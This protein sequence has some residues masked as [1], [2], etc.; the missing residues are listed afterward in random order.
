MFTG[1]I[2]EIGEVKYINNNNFGTELEISCKKVLEKAMVGDSI[3]T[4]GVCLTI[5]KLFERSFLAELMFETTR[6]SNLSILKKGDKVNLEK[7]VRL[8]SFMGGHLVTGDVDCVGEII[9]KQNDGFSIVYTIKIPEDYMKFIV[10][11]GRV[12]IDGASLTISKDNEKNFQISLIP[13]S[14][15]NITLSEKKIGDKV[16]IETDIIGKYV[17][18]MVRYSEKKEKGKNCIVDEKFLAENGFF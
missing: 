9:D 10:Y 16:N 6:N 8:D 12:A 2:E 17:E 1:L 5:T 11:K 3:A 14:Q 18:K 7:S 4:N 13:H 15:K